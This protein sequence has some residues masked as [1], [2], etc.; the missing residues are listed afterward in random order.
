MKITTPVEPVVI[1]DAAKRI[2]R[3]AATFLQGFCAG[4][5]GAAFVLLWL[6]K[7]GAC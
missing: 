2:R 1:M 4:A 3:D 5:G 6:L 7:V